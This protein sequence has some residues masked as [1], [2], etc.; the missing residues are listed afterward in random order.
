MEEEKEMKKILLTVLMSLIL[1]SFAYAD[2]LSFAPA[3]DGSIL[4]DLQEGALVPVVGLQLAT[5]FDGLLEVRGM[6][7]GDPQSLS[8]L[9]KIGVG[10]GVNLVILTNKLGQTWTA[11][12]INPTVGIAPIYSLSDK[13]MGIG[14]YATIVK[15]EF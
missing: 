9:N 3:I 11:K 14:I 15:I 6:V 2:T 5:A 13:T 7:I 1:C 12:I 4:Y 8:E 10:I